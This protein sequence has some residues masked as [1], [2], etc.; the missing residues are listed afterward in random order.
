[1][2]P[3]YF[4]NTAPSS[5]RNTPLSTNLDENTTIDLTLVDTAFLVSIEDNALCLRRLFQY[6]NLILSA[7]RIIIVE[8]FSHS[9]KWLIVF[10]VKNLKRTSL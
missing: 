9:F 6:A 3:N 7:S 4:T 2:C 5:S 1:M 8:R 10:R